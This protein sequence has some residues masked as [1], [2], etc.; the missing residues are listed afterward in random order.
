MKSVTIY[1]H[2]IYKSSKEK[3]LTVR[4]DLVRHAQ[5]IGVKPT[6]RKFGCSKN[7]VRK[8]LKAF[9]DNGIG[10]LQ[11]GRKGPHYIPHKTSAGLEEHIVNCRQRAP[12]FGPKRLKWA[13]GIEAS[14]S[15]IARIIKQRNL[16]R[17][18][19]KKYQRKQD[20]R[21]LKAETHNALLHAQLDV[22]HL[23]D[24]PY[25]WEQLINKGFLPKYQYTI[26]DTKTGF[27]FLGY[28]KEYSEEYSTIMVSKYLDH[29]KKFGIDSSSVTIQTDNGSEFGARKRDVLTP[30]FVNTIVCKYR[31][32]HTYIPPGMCNAN[33]DVESVHSTIE[34]EFFDIEKF[35]SN[36]DFWQKINAYQLFYNLVRPNFSKAGK[37][38]SQIILEDHP[39]INTQITI[40]SVVNLD[41]EFCM[42]HGLAS[43]ENIPGGQS[44]QKLPALSLL[45]FVLS[46][47]PFPIY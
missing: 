5:Q 18:R 46:T 8:A 4:M 25:Y 45:P 43:T 31:A 32:Q 9:E 41:Y 24:I 14:E 28:A 10:G 20:L 6:A 26:R 35:H 47:P 34:P 36:E 38:P 17:K 30:G 13:F 19:R 2:M 11:D 27:L 7:T 15:A 1:C 44:L 37:T 12:C 29:L 40:H 16:T 33:A 21:A 23:Y 42:K 3:K 39:G 22:K